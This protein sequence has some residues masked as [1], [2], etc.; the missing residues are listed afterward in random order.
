[1][2]RSAVIASSEE[3]LRT[4]GDDLAGLHKALAAV[5]SVMRP[6]PTTLCPDESVRE[7]L[8][9]FSQRR[10]RHL[11]VCEGDKLVGVVSDRDLLRFL[12]DRP[13]GIEAPVGEMMTREP[14]TI[15][16]TSPISEAATLMI[17]NRIH[18]LPVVNASGDVEGIITSSDLLGVL[19]AVQYWIE[20]RLD[21]AV[22]A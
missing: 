14:R 22:A 9:L 6:Y 21:P 4:P 10:F 12:I 15:R 3:T 19:H 16:P 13:D 2:R 20:R 8:A 5:S 17:R 1:M 7:A 18:C 11:L